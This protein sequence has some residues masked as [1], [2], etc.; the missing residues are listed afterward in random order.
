MLELD[1]C[2][3][4]STECRVDESGNRTYIK[5]VQVMTERE[6]PPI[7]GY[8]TSASVA[9]LDDFGSP[10]TWYGYVDPWAFSNNYQIRRK[11]EITDPSTGDIRTLWLITI[12]YDSKPTQSQKKQSPRENPVD[13]E[14][15]V[16]GGFSLFKQGVWRDKDDEAIINAFGEPY[17]PPIEI[18]SAFDTVQI[19]FNTKKIDLVQSNKNS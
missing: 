19:S 10:Y 4:V 14:A 2:K 11:E 16:K 3:E 13:D 1:V 7:F 12:T 8:R 17:D 9:N 15:T 5:V 18:D 6:R